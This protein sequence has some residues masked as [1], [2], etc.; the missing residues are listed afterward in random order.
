MRSMAALL[1]VRECFK[2]STEEVGSCNAG[3]YNQGARA[4]FVERFF[5]VLRMVHRYLYVYTYN[6]YTY[7][8]IYFCGFASRHIFI[9]RNMNVYIRKCVDGCQPSHRSPNCA[10]LGVVLSAL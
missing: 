10:A 5:V 1:A 3:V 4:G 2:G 9:N 7:V 8:Y 6:I